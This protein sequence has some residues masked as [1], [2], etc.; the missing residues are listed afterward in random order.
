MTSICFCISV[1]EK[2]TVRYRNN[3]NSLVGD[4]REFQKDNYLQGLICSLV[5]KPQVLRKDRIKI[6]CLAFQLYCTGKR[7]TAHFDSKVSSAEGTLKTI[8]IFHK[9]RRDSACLP[10][11]SFLA[12][13]M[14]WHV[15]IILIDGTWP[16]SFHGTMK[17]V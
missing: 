15:T 6:I 7:E 2:T 10:F 5:V 17:K 1:V 3:F 8:S 16:L 12:A 14:G 9:G 4:A 11:F 13:L